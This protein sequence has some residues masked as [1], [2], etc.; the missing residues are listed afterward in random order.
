[1]ENQVNIV[2]HSRSFHIDELMAIALLKIYYLGGKDV[3]ITRTREEQELSVA[4][5]DKETFVID[6]GFNYNP[7]M[8]NFDHHQKG[9]EVKWKCGTP[10]S[11]CGMIWN[12]LKSQN[13]FKQK[14]N[15]EM[16]R[17]IEERLIKPIDKHDNGIAGFDQAEFLMLYNRN[18]HDEAIMNRQF[19]RALEAAIDFYH[20]L[21]SFIKN[22]LK[23]KKE[24]DKALNKHKDLPYVVFDRNMKDAAKISCSH[25]NKMLMIVPHSKGKWTIQ[26]VPE[27]KNRL[28]TQRCSFP[29]EVRGK[30]RKALSKIQG[31]EKFLFVHKNGF[32][33]VIE[34][35]KEEAI[36]YAEI[37]IKIS[38]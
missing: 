31:M 28:F 21:F 22:E 7:E 13:I 37:L 1:M 27:S 29:E 4:V 18:N 14:M 26:A 6:V 16:V 8:L 25:K 20:N 11:S 2:T 19:N 24:I 9:C 12:W 10:M 23:D 38:R 17:A 30:D 15:D 5:A 32:M 35:S 34:A 36:Q 3:K 33:G